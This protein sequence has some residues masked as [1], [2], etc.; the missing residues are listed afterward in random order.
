MDLS[1]TQR[2]TA[3][4]Q[5][6]Y[7]E[8]AENFADARPRLQAGVQ[9]VLAG[10]KP[11]TRVLEIGCG[12]GKVGRALARLGV[13]TYVGLD[14]SQAMLERARKYTTDDEGPRTKDEKEPSG[15]RPSSF[16]L[17]SADLTSPS[18]PTVIPGELFT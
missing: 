1:T 12:D 9:R 6:F 17:L 14:S 16:V 8:H 11:A 2:L 4:N 15:L 7:A 18:W 13:A 3:L 10:V 5:Q